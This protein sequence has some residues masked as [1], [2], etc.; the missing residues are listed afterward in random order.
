MLHAV[1]FGALA[2][3]YAACW[4]LKSFSYRYGSKNVDL[5]HFV[6]SARWCALTHFLCPVVDEVC[7]L[8][9]KKLPSP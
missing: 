6:G 7:L 8:I 9:D 1:A 3:F 5:L 2:V 4:G